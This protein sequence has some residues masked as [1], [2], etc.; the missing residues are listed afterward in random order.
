MSL[1]CTT[2]SLVLGLYFSRNNIAL[3]IIISLVY[4]IFI[5]VRFNKKIF[6]LCL[7]LFASGVTISNINLECDSKNDIYS[8]FVIE[9]KDNYYLF[10][11]KL[12][13]FYIYEKDTNKE[14]GDYLVIQSK[15]NSLKINTFESQFNFKEYLHNKGIKRELE[16]N[17]I[18]CKFYS[19]FKLH[20]FKKKAISKFDQNVAP[21]V[22]AILFNEKDY[23]SETI[24]ITSE[25]KVIS[26]FSLS[27]IY[28]HFFFASLKYILSLKLSEKASEILPFIILLP[29]AFF[30]F[31]KIGTIRVF[32]I[33]ILKLINKY[34]LKN[35]FTH[36][37]LVSILALIFITFNYHLVY[38]E[39]F[40]V[41]FLLSI[42]IP[43]L[44]T[45]F[46]SLPNLRRKIAL[47][48]CIHILM[49][50]ITFSDGT[51]N[52]FQII[53][54]MV[55]IPLNTIFIVTS[56]FH[57][58]YPS[59]GV[60]NKIGGIIIWILKKI[61][62]A[63]IAIPISNLGGALPFLF[64]LLLLLGVYYLEANRIKHFKI[65]ISLIFVS[66]TL[67]ICPIQDPIINGVYFIN[68]GQ[69]DSILIKNRT[70]TVLIDTGG[71][72]NSDLATETLIP[73]FNKNK[74]THIDALIITHDDFDHNGAAQ[75]L[76]KNFKVYK[77]LTKRDEFPYKVGDIYLENLNNYS[78]MEDNDN[79]LVLSLKFM[80]KKWLFM[81]DAT[82]NVEKYL[83]KQNISLD[84][85]I[86]KIGH[87]GSKTS[88]CEDFLKACSP[89]T[90]I[91]SVG[92]KNNYQHP[93]ESV[94]DLLNKY[95][96]DIRRTDKEGTISYLSLLT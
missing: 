35:R 86:L 41:G 76:I 70:K 22:E 16:N 66:L 95:N 30:S 91:I 20:A 26:L 44:S 47:W 19:P 68:V 25:L 9:V 73:F 28:L 13:K 63:N 46:K 64:Y 21:L 33:Y 54:P 4:L 72:K 57:L 5:F 60:A 31:T 90:A 7:I 42:L 87:H 93:S 96:I 3:S 38:Q 14:M 34:K 27:G 18:D 24:K 53:F 74:I 78:G 36:I 71:Q 49:L 10:Q 51:L 40:Y 81:G 6:L 61:S 80:N 1:L 79:S 83:L 56:S 59:L 11:S 67:S 37:E 75:S 65:T 82:T 92:E 12:E 8:G 29:F 69:G 45:S 52:L 84:C 85:D 15:P 23:S 58:L 94:I 62:I 32:A 2:F 48:L 17:V 89:N 50:P 55:L 43:F 39:A 88:T 77:Y